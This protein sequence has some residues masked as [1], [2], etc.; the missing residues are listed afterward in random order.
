MEYQLDIYFSI[1]S[2]L[3]SMG[4]EFFLQKG[5]TTHQA[6]LEIHSSRST[7]GNIGG[8]RE[9]RSIRKDILLASGIASPINSFHF[10]LFPRDHPLYSYISSTT[11]VC[12][13]K[14]LASGLLLIREVTASFRDF[15]VQLLS[16]SFWKRTNENLNDTLFVAVYIISQ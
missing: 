2:S 1:Q 15:I 14:I 16:S 4:D 13:W 11:I 9:I 8:K 5:R 6:T 12:P 3:I 10:F 7:I